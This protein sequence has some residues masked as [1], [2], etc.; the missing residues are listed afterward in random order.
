MNYYSHQHFTG[1]KH[2]SISCRC[3]SLQMSI[4]LW[5]VIRARAINL[6]GIPQFHCYKHLKPIINMLFGYRRLQIKN[7]K[8]NKVMSIV[9]AILFKGMWKEKFDQVFKAPFHT[10]K[11]IYQSIDLRIPTKLIFRDVCFTRPLCP[12]IIRCQSK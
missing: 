1:W 5:H 9:S 8:G 10:S 6:T 12:I 7:I 3:R 11:E 2:L 4:I